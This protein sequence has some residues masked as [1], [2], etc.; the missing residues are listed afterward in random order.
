MIMEIVLPGGDRVDAHL[1]G[2]VIR[3]DQDGPAPE[4]F[5]L[6]LASIGT[7]AGIYIARFCQK[8]QIPTDGIRIRQNAIHNQE[9]RMFE[10][11]DLEIQLPEGFPGRYRAAVIR[12]AEQCSV[13]K[14]LAN[15]PEIITRTSDGSSAMDR[16][17]G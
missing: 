3:T 16:P 10:K 5:E 12:A 4:P 9:T 7:C 13:K 14:H 6:F 15:P 1:D 11:I 2:Q 8:R 17:A